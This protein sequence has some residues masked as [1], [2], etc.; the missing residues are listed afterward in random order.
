MTPPW[1]DAVDVWRVERTPRGVVVHAALALVYCPLTLSAAGWKQL[2]A[3]AP[4]PAERTAV[5]GRLLRGARDRAGVVPLGG[6]AV[7]DDQ[8]ALAVQPGPSG[9]EH[10]A[11]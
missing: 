7:A 1:W 9:Q 6:I 3:A 5:V 11:D 4:T 10:G 8:V 2:T